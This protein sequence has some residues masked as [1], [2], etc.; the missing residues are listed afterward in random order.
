MST[1]VNPENPAKANGKNAPFNFLPF[2]LGLVLPGLG[3][4]SVGER[5]RAYRILAG[6]LVLWIGGL[7]IGGLGSVRSFEPEY[8]TGGNGP[9]RNLWFYAQMGAGPIA[10]VFDQLDKKL[11]RETPDENRISASLPNQRI[12]RIP[13]ETAIGHAAD[14]GMLFCSLAGLM[15]V[16]IAIDAG[17]R[18]PSNRRATEPVRIR[19]STS[20]AAQSG[21][22]S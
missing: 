12:T 1:Q 15:N 9:K 3:H 7:L 16:A 22:A 19:R 13:S 20:P 5:G 17:R 6:F 10:L 18:G 2:V 21:G 11:I 14:F 8:A 4:F